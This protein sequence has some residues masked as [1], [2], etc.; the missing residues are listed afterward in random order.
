[1]GA[2]AYALAMPWIPPSTI[3]ATQADTQGFVPANRF[4]PRHLI[5]AA[6]LAAGVWALLWLTAAV[7][8]PR[9]LRFFLLFFF[10]MAAITL[11]WYGFGVTLLAQPWRFHLAMEMAFTLSLVFAVRLLLQRWT[12]LRRPVAVAFAILCACNS[13]NTGTMRGG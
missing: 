4:T 2:L 6:V 12:A 8:A 5:Y 10:C 7:R 3:F 11:G 1:M 9:Y 13:C